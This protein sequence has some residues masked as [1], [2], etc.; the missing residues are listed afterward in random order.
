MSK[1][2]KLALVISDSAK[3]QD[4]AG[5]LRDAHDW[6]APE[7]A[8]MQAEAPGRGVHAPASSS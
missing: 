8:D 5:P 7:Q 1:D 2:P 3:A 4:G 6:V